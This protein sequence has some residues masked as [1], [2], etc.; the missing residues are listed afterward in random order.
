[1]ERK[2]MTPE[3]L[4]KLLK[5]PGRGRPSKYP[6]A[7]LEVSESLSFSA[8]DEYTKAQALAHQYAQNHKEL[9]VSFMTRWLGENGVIVRVK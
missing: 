5:A 3:E 2:M 8:K 9:G 1:M 4:E 7:E 6:F